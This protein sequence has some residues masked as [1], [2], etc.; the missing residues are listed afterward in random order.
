M[1]S[2]IIF[3]P[4]G[5]WLEVMVDIYPRNRH[6]AEAKSVISE[7]FDFTVDRR[8]KWIVSCEIQC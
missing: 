6:L 1:D 7:S 2:W 4:V 3:K 5:Q 8:I